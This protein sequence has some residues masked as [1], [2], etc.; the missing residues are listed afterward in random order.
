MGRV[1]S[2]APLDLVD[3]LFDLER[4]QIVEL[5]FVGLKLGIEL[6]FASLLLYDTSVFALGTRLEIHTP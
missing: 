3:F 6:V 4:F 2:T 5:R 1:L